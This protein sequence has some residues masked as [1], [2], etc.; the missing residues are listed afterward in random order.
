MRYIQQ[1]SVQICLYTSTTGHLQ[2]SVPRLHRI[3]RINI[4]FGGCSYEEKRAGD[5]SSHHKQL[6]KQN[7]G[8]FVD[9]ICAECKRVCCFFLALSRVISQRIMSNRQLSD[10]QLSATRTITSLIIICK[11]QGYLTDNYVKQAALSHRQ[12]C[13]KCWAISQTIMCKRQ[14]YLLESY[15]QQAG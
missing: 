6:G 5:I 1:M 14:G 15:G 9:F 4:L 11:K 12:L 7:D 2:L 3:F 13:A 10:R 8:V